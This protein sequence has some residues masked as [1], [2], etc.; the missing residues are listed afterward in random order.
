MFKLFHVYTLIVIDSTAGHIEYRSDIE[1]PKLIDFHF[2]TGLVYVKDMF[3]NL[4]QLGN[5]Q[6]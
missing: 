3:G 5:E 1:L 2:R 6:R 4:I